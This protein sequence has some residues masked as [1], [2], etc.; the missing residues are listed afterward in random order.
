MACLIDNQSDIGVG[1]VFLRGS[2]GYAERI[3]YI[4]RDLLVHSALDYF[5]LLHPSVLFVDCWP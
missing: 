3:V 2:M 1:R 4:D 5:V